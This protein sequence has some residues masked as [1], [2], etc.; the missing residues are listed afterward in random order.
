MC[1]VKEVRLTVHDACRFVV[2]SHLLDHRMEDTTGDFRITEREQLAS[3]GDAIACTE[4]PSVRQRVQRNIKS[5]MGESYVLCPPVLRRL[6]S[7]VPTLISE[8]TVHVSI[9]SPSTEVNCFVSGSWNSCNWSGNLD[10]EY[11]RK[12]VRTT[13]A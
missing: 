9:C 6:V 7:R 12:K 10:P 8:K 2:A 3:F 11:Q 1:P 13:C 5:S 4:S